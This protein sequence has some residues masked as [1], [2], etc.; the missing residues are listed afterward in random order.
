MNRCA[1]VKADGGRCRARAQEGYARCYN[2]REDTREARAAA[3]SKGGRTGGNGRSGAPSPAGREIGALK[4]QLQKIADGVLDGAVLHGQAA[5]AVQALHAK[6]RVLE[7]ERRWKELGE[8]EEKLL[9]L[10]RRLKN[11]GRAS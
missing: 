4:R 5:V 3:A 8:V 9:K 6:A 7:L 2:H 1:F 11:P 10:E